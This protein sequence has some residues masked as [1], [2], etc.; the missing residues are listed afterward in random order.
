V[1]C[2]L[3]GAWVFLSPADLSRNAGIVLFIVGILYGLLFVCKGKS[4]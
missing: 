1:G 3:L 2:I 4:N